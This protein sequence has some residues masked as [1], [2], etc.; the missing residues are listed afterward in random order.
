MTKKKTNIDYIKEIRRE[1]IINPRTRIQENSLKDKKKRRQ[2]DKRIV[3]EG[4]N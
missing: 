1:W 2:E 3:K 4:I